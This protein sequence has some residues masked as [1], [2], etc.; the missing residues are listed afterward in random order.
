MAT[1]GREQRRIAEGGQIDEDHTVDKLLCHGIGHGECQASLP[2]ATRSRECAEAGAASSS[3]AARAA[4]SGPH[5]PPARS[6]GR[7]KAWAWS[8]GNVAAMAS[9]GD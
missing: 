7:G 6:V 9:W 2:D 1:S 3:R 8:S 4:A 5:A